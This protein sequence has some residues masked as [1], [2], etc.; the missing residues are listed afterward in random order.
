MRHQAQKGFC[1]I[2][3]G[4][5][6]HQKVYLLYVPSSTKIL[7]SYDVVFDAILSSALAYTLQPYSEAM[8]MRPDVT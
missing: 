2:F 7:S 3:V 5:L 1:V 8:V 4:I 6:H